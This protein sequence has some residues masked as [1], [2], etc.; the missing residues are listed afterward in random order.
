MNING[1]NQLSMCKWLCFFKH[2]GGR[3]FVTNKFMGGITQCFLVVRLTGRP[4]GS[5]MRLIMIR[6]MRLVDSWSS[7]SSS[8]RPAH[9]QDKCIYMLFYTVWMKKAV[10]H[11]EWRKHYYILNEGEQGI[12][13]TEKSSRQALLDF[14][15]WGEQ[16]IPSNEQ[17][18]F[19]WGEQGKASGARG[20]PQWED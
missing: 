5:T 20:R 8:S 10:L 2:L 1:L 13:I 15:G 3:E 12:C 4:R 11:T 19:G 7:W 14:L 17:L 16:G 18:I 6:A 9:F